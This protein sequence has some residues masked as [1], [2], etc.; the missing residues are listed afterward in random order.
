MAAGSKT[1]E[2]SIDSVA[3]LGSLL[4]PMQGFHEDPEGAT[5]RCPAD[6]QEMPGI[7]D[8]S[9]I[10]LSPP[11][12]GSGTVVSLSFKVLAREFC[13]MMRCEQSCPKST[14]VTR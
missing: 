2:L 11:L 8:F 12:L 13:N 3:S 5:R 9:Q 6:L 10:R 1:R 14:D 4:G 7:S